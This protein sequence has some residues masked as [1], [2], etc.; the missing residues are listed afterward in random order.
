[1]FR[2]GCGIRLYRFLITFQIF[3]RIKEED[4]DR[5]QDLQSTR[6]ILIKHLSKGHKQTNVQELFDYNT[7]GV[8]NRPSEELVSG[9]VLKKINYEFEEAHALDRLK[10]PMLILE[11]MLQIQQYAT[12]TAI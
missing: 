5:I 4:L 10:V 8:I 3:T 7:S 12:G 1:M 2:T 11:C 9:V 6:K